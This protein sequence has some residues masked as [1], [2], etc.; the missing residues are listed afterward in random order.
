VNQQSSRQ[1]TGSSQAARE[2]VKQQPGNQQQPGI[3]CASKA[4]A[5]LPLAPKKT[6]FK[7]GIKN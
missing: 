1:A 2:S 6:R 4:A 5:R 7:A 3:S